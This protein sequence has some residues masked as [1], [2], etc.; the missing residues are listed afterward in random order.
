MSRDHLLA[1]GAGAVSA[2]FYLSVGLGSFGAMI[3]AYMA[4]LPLFLMG[5]GWGFRAAAIASAVAT[6]VIL[7]AASPAAAA[8][9]AVT[10]AAPVLVVVY[11]ALQSRP[12]AN[13][14]VEW[15]PPGYLMASVAGLA[16]AILI[17]V[18]VYYAGDEGGLEGATQTLLRAMLGTIVGDVPTQRIDLVIA[19]LSRFFPALAL[20]SWQMVAMGN[21]LL[22]QGVLARFNRNRRPGAPFAG[23]ELPRWPS[24]AFVAFAAAAFMPG[25]IGFLCGNGAVIMAVPLFFLGLSVIHAVTKRWP[26]R[27]FLLL[28]LYLLLILSGWPALFIAALGLAEQWLQLRRRFA[29]PRGDQGEE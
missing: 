12:T 16:L 4:Q 3:L 9:F 27:A 26:G 6:A 18:G 23:L 21:G 2:V 28:L 5:L 10:G 11:L 15:Y 22:A 25:Q 19:A 8:L 17:A 1:L 14:P 7:A 20:T 13:G 29:G 24:F